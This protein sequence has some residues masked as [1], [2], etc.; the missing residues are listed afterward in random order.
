M[1]YN[2]FNILL[3]FIIS[4]CLFAMPVNVKAYITFSSG[5]VKKQ[6]DNYSNFSIIGEPII[7]NNFTSGPF[8]GSM[9]YIFQTIPKKT[10][11]LS[12]QLSLTDQYGTAVVQ[13][14]ESTDIEYLDPV[15]AY[16]YELIT[17]ITEID[18][19]LSLT[20]GTY[21][22]RAFID[23][24]ENLLFD[25][26]ESYIVITDP[27]AISEMNVDMPSPINIPPPPLSDAGISIDM[28]IS[29]VGYEN[30]VSTT[31]IE[32]NCSAS[33]NDEKWIAVVGQN[34]DDLD[35]YQ[36]EVNFD[37]DRL[38]FM[39][40]VDG[41]PAGG[42]GNLLNMNEG[43]TIGF[44]AIEYRSGVI[45]I[46]NSIVGSNSDTAPEGTGILALLKFRILDDT[47]VNK[48]KINNAWFLNCSQVN[49][50]SRSFLRVASIVIRSGIFPVM[51]SQIIW[52]W[53]S[54][55]ITGL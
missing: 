21:L 46:A 27:I 43:T 10:W 39:T 32:S 41:N 15:D 18:F 34:V 45:N 14:F 19:S 44:Q 28:D 26:G 50:K 7:A 20:E 52:I 24:N 49:E 13:A 5:G 47:P 55:L 38:E 23:S 2:H 29:T 54:L 11:Q 16:Y 51:A 22:L 48:L 37:P 36:I 1:R 3:C 6:T 25:K 53:V 31:H 40:G 9:G 42:I 4:T 33:I 12:G 17:G 8:T 35:T 30:I